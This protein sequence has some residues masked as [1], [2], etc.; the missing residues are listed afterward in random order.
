MHETTVLAPGRLYVLRR[1]GAKANLIPFFFCFKGNLKI[2]PHNCF[3]KLCV[4]TANT[5]IAYKVPDKL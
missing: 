3:G 1:Y 5:N 4:R 2:K